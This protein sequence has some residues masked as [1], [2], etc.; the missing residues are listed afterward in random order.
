MS[1]HRFYKSRICSSDNYELSRIVY[2]RFLL[3]Q[4]L[5]FGKVDKVPYIRVFGALI[6]LKD[7]EVA[8][9]ENIYE[10]IYL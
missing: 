9:Y 6:K 7:H 8:K 1:R 10:V 5:I 3:T 2:K 4:K